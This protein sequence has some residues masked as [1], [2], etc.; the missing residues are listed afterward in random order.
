MIVGDPSS[1]ENVMTGEY[2]T[3]HTNGKMTY[4][5]V[6]RGKNENELNER[7]EELIQ[8]R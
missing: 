8:L 2:T 5:Q 7:D 4:A 3:Q 6:V 1:V